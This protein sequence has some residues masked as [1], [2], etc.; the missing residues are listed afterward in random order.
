MRFDDEQ[1][2]I[3]R[4]FA[5]QDDTSWA[6]EV[7]SN[8]RTFRLRGQDD[9]SQGNEVSSELAKGLAGG[10]VMGAAGG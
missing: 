8:Q 9:S 7:S 6:D 2:Q 1:P 5:P 10:A 3:V 4:R